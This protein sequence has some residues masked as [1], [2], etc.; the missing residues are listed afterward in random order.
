MIGEISDQ[1]KGSA[2]RAKDLSVRD[3]EISFSILCAA[4]Q[5]ELNRPLND[6]AQVKDN[7]SAISAA[8][9]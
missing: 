1:E 5:F 9:R 4:L 8:L 7:S 2:L 3:Y 6:S